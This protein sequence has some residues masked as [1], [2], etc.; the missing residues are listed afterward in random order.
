MKIYRS[1][2]ELKEP[3]DSIVTVGNFDGVHGG[4][5]QIIEKLVQKARRFNCRSVLIT[6]QP[7]PQIVK[8]KKGDF[9]GLLTPLD[10]K[11]TLLK[12][13]AIDI[14]LILPF[15]KEL[16]QMDAETFIR[17]VLKEKIGA[18]HIIIGFNHSFGNKR[19][20]DVSLLQEL[21]D[22]YNFSVEL[23]EPIKIKNIVVSSSQIRNSLKKGNVNFANAM[24]ARNYSVEGKVI[25][26]EKLG[27]QIGF[28]T[29][30][31]V[32]EDVYKLI[33][34]DGVYSVVVSYNGEKRG[35]TVY[36]GKRPTVQGKNRMIEIYLHDY[37]G[38]LYGCNLK[39]EFLDYIRK[40]KKFS[41]VDELR[42]NIQNDINSSKDI[43]S[44]RRRK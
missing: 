38:N 32:I 41:S 21:S 6:F 43:L 16:S 35:G 3:K 31:I 42:E 37:S 13:T 14:L 17:K 44:V 23:V 18:I 19:T 4:H 12:N 7:H 26:G 10:E 30:N 29:A 27:Q 9:F 24:L 33:P 20:G 5:L 28:P 15:N 2:T 36:I 22:N 8:S 11:I 1:F 34:G 40:E 39:V 25:T